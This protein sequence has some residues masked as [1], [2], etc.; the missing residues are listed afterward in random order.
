MKLSIETLEILQDIC[1]MVGYCKIY[2]GYSGR[3]MYGEECIGIA[4]ERYCS[5]YELLGRL[6]SEEFPEPS[7]DSLGT[8]KIYYWPNIIDDGTKLEK[9][10]EN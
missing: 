7:R 2:R 5:D 3:G 4:T 1:D 6:W 8:G 10:D 9:T